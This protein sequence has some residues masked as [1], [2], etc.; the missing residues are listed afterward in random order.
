MKKFKAYDSRTKK[1]SGAEVLMRAL[2][3]QQSDSV[4]KLPMSTKMLLAGKNINLPNTDIKQV[5]NTLYIGRRGE[6]KNSTQIRV[7]GLNV[8]TGKNYLDNTVI[9]MKKLREEGITHFTT[10]ITPVPP[11]LID[12][13]KVLI[14]RLRKLGMEA[15][16]VST[17]DKK[18]YRLFVRL[19][20]SEAGGAR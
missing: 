14:A 8:D 19:S 13:A 5:G 15:G 10:D 16:L 1:L 2:D 17:V 11:K 18:K 7:Y 3:Q 6:G 9:Y 20:P 4:D 12:L